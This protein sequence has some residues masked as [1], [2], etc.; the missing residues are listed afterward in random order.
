MGEL[1][2][3][4]VV[5]LVAVTTGARAAGPPDVFVDEAT[6]ETPV[7]AEYVEDPSGTM[8]VHDVL[9][10]PDGAFTLADST[11]PNFG[12]TDSAYWLRFRAVNMSS[13]PLDQVIEVAYPL[14]DHVEVTVPGRNAATPEQQVVTGDRL[15]FS[16]RPLDYSTFLVPVEIPAGA[17]E[18]IYIRVAGSSSLQIP[19]TLWNPGELVSHIDRRSITLGVYYGLMFVMALY[20]LFL[21]VTIR[22]RSYLFYVLFVASF[23]L[24]QMAMNGIA[25]QYLWPEHPWWANK[26]IPFLV[27]MVTVWGLIFTRSFIDTARHVPRLHSFYAVSPWVLAALLVP[28]L[29]LP[30]A[31]MVKTAILLT[32]VA[33]VIILVTAVLCWR[34]GYRPA[35]YFTIAWV[36]FLTGTVLYSLKSLGLLPANPLTEHTQQ[37]G[38]AMEVVL[39]SFALGDRINLLKREK[40]QARAEALEMKAQQ[41][42]LLRAEVDEK[43]RDLQKAVGDLE[44]VNTRLQEMDQQKTR[45]YQNLT[46]ELRTPL[47]L[48]IGPLEASL[49]GSMGKLPQQV[50]FHHVIM[51]RNA[52]RLLRLIN[53]LLDLAKL[54]EQRMVLDRSTIE[55]VSFCRTLA[56][57]FEPMAEKKRID[58]EFTSSADQLLARFDREKL[59]KIF[60]NLLSNAFKFT[61]LNGK[62]TFDIKAP[63]RSGPGQQV[64]VSVEDTGQGIDSQSLEHVFD[65]FHQ[66]DSSTTREYEGT[67]IGLALVK[68]YV[69]LHE[70]DVHVDS[71][72]GQGT[73]FTLR[74]PCEVMDP[75]EAVPSV[76]VATSPSDWVATELPE[77]DSGES[78]RHQLMSSGHLELAA[79]ELATLDEPAGDA[80]STAAT[81]SDTILV[82]EDN[83]DMRRYMRGILAAEHHVIEARD[84]VEGLAAALEHRPSLIVT[85]V[86]MPRMDGY[87]LLAALRKDSHTEHIPV[88]VV[89]A[90]AEDAEKIAS[91]ESGAD[92]YLT[93][94]FNAKEL[95]ARTRNL[96]RI[97]RQEREIEELNRHLTE[98]VLKRYLPGDLIDQIVSGEVHLEQE[99]KTTQATIMF[100]DLV[101]FT[102]TSAELPASALSRVLN[103]FFSRMSDEVFA[104]GGTI[105]KFLGDGMMIMFGA[106]VAMEPTV[107]VDRAVRCGR[108]MQAAMRELGNVWSADDLPALTMRVGIHHGPVVV[109]NF[110]SDRRMDFTA[111]GPVVN[112]A[113]RIQ[114][115]APAGE[116]LIS[117][118]VRSLVT[119]FQLRAAGNFQLKGISGEV[120]CYSVEAEDALTE[121]V[122][123]ERSILRT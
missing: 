79:L 69:E 33:A 11:S 8:T 116:V 40:D 82:V 111:I 71:T 53:Q 26:A 51:L 68:E 78:M 31:I 36:A 46:H 12:Y 22:E 80:T 42:D 24:T 34:G 57:A 37:I 86:M 2:L 103:Q 63:R 95:L 81:S 17:S 77:A 25:F 94:P 72:L 88:I 32:S 41:A 23:L 117:Q 59:E 108:A 121:A 55:L 56:D 50:M 93:K 27:L 91:L 99:A 45:F 70:G 19:L 101:G 100:L 43:T 87:Q 48:I 29:A 97:R 49:G 102:S 114:S 61:P 110:G 64:V 120:A 89:T 44:S 15:P 6:S 7:V 35:R 118:A 47:T 98:N 105:D 66:A 83:S 58:F 65:R 112:M 123:D 115:V 84:G 67:G 1:R 5:C 85:D 92:D 75:T 60:F 21:F 10:L 96:L 18:D 20:N 62:I 74:L 122:S 38:S 106:P 9:A 90:R 4:V 76:A 119:G 52:R 107:Q 13:S 54:E 3:A 39:L 14:L 104:H 113:E 30:Y 109:G 16:R 73:K 28:A